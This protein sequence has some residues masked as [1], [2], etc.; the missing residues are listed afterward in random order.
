MWVLASVHGQSSSS[1]ATVMLELR[2]ALNPPTSLEWTGSNPYNWE[3][4]GYDDN[5][6][7]QVQIKHQGLTG[8]LSVSVANLT[9]LEQFEVMSNQPIGSVPSLVELNLLQ[10]LLLNNK[11]LSFFPANSFFSLMSL[12]A[13][14][15]D[16]NPFSTWEIPRSF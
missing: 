12:Q 5:R 3:H 6:V 2:V 16:H 14:Y 9:A 11:N 13:V 4:V 1:D 10:H 8:S 15:L 7:T